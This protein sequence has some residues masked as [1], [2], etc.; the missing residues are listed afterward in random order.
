MLPGGRGGMNPKQLAAMMKQMGISMEEIDD[1]EEVVIRTQKEEIV[2]TDASVSK[3]V[4][5]G[6]GTTWQVAGKEARRPRAA[7]SEAA[8]PAPPATPALAHPKELFTEDDVALVAQQA[9]V[10]KDEAHRALVAAN[11][12]PAEAILKLLGDE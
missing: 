12:E 2:I 10:S 4:A 8:A 1:V 11:G 9:N 6:Q 3:M 5:R 7:A